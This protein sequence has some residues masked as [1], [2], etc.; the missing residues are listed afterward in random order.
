MVSKQEL[1]ALLASRS[2]LTPERHNTPNDSQYSYIRFSQDQ[3]REYAIQGMER[4]L[5]KAS[6]KLRRDF[7]QAKV[8]HQA[9]YQFSKAQEIKV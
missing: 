7:T 8:K 5:T 6:D 4:S 9:K 1:D 2:K 3:K